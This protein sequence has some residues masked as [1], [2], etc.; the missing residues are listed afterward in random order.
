MEILPVFCWYLTNACEMHVVN[1]FRK[2]EQNTADGA[3]DTTALAKWHILNRLHD[4][5][6]KGV[7]G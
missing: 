7:K 5:N 2:L 1:N 4:R 6:E 3:D